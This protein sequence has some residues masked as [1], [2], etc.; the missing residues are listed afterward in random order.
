M[1]IALIGYPGR[2]ARFAAGLMDSDGRFE[3]CARIE[4]QDP[5]EQTL[6]KSKAQV[7][8]DLTR[9]GLGA[10]H[11]HIILQAG[12]HAVIGTSGVTDSDD[13]ALHRAALEAQRGCMVVPNFSLGACAQQYLAKQIAT[14]FPSIEILEEHHLQ[15]LDSPS[16]TARETQAQLARLRGPEA[17]EIPIHSRRL[18]GPLANQSVV[19]SGPGE[20]LRMVHETYDLAVY[21]PGI[22]LALERVTGLVGLERGLEAAL[23]GPS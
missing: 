11:G 15:K 14:R 4:S 8:L 7:A 9:A 5:L 20:V 13:Q 23:F 12:V 17:R 3:V 16:G 19:F 21:G 1:R 18:P 10:E 2:M 22:C 6:R